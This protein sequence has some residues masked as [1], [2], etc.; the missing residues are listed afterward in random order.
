MNTNFHPTLWGNDYWIFL[1]LIT[2]AY[3]EDPINEHKEI[4]KNFFHNLVLPCKNCQ[5][6]YDIQISNLDIN[7]YLS[8]NQ[9]LFKWIIIIQNKIYEKLNKNI[10]IKTDIQN[11]YEITGKCA[12]KRVDRKIKFTINDQFKM[13]QLITLSFPI[14]PS[15]NDKKRYYNFFSL[16]QYVLPC[17]NCRFLYKQ[18]FNKLDINLY[19]NNTY[20]LYFWL[21][22][23]YNPEQKEFF[24]NIKRLYRD[25][26]RAYLRP[27]MC[28]KKNRILQNKVLKMM[29]IEKNFLN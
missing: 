25:N 23:I 20:Q 4:Y 3:P 29:E 26:D 12:C 24:S 13:L 2:L 28:C 8:N 5:D 1:H 19:L 6:D 17:E 7:N 27:T 9:S 15:D 18:N 22:K 16:L 21:N 11:D 10:V 14:E